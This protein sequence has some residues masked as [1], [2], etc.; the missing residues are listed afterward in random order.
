[1]THQST[2]LAHCGTNHVDESA[3][4]SVAV[5]AW[6]RTWHPVA[7]CDLIDALEIAVREH[8]MEITRRQYAMNSAGSRLFG[9][10]DIADAK[11]G[12]ASAIGF[13]NATD[14]SMAVGIT[15]GTRVFVCDNLA[16]SGDFI[17]FRRHTAGLTMETLIEMLVNAVGQARARIKEFRTWHESLALV[18][19]T[20]DQAYVVTWRILSEGILPGRSF[21]ALHDLLYSENKYDPFTLWGQHEAATELLTRNGNLLTVARAHRK[22]NALMDSVSSEIEYDTHRRDCLA[23]NIPAIVR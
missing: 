11:N 6:T 4:R 17:A 14:K 2:L 3:I 7:H 22:L 5:P 16:I 20:M 19:L 12:M 8:E 23:R 15:V 18:H 21:R 1:M 13:R 10:W 9:V